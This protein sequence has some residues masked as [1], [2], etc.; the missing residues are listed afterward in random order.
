MNS[1]MIMHCEAYRMAIA[2]GM[3]IAM[4]TADRAPLCELISDSDFASDCGSD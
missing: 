3:M 1:D 2:S 4:I